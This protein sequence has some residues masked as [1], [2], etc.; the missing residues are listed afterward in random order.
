MKRKKL[1]ALL[2]VLVVV[3]S[4]LVLVESAIA[5]T[6]PQFTIQKS[7]A[8]ITCKIKNQLFTPVNDSGH[9]I[10]LYYY[11]KVT[12]LAN[13]GTTYYP[14]FARRYGQ[15][16]G[17]VP[18]TSASD[19]EFTTISIPISNYIDH[20]ND[21]LYVPDCGEVK[22]QVQAIK[23]YIDIVEFTGM[24][25]GNYYNFAGE[26]SS[27]SEPLISYTEP[28]PTPTTPTITNPTNPTVSY[29]E[30]KVNFTLEDIALVIVAAVAVAALL[31]ALLSFHTHRV[32]N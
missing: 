18:D 30:S 4:N 16:T 31:V 7:D 27:W 10:K 24:L 28:T 9:T 11:F 22:V 3:A 15:Y 25:A 32:K 26:K 17:S 23:G 21:F 19:S 8:Y 12:S 2:L 6:P 13:N 14:D 20:V 5:Q 29:P 1:A